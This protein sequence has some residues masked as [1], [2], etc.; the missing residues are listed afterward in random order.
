MHCSWLSNQPLLAD[1]HKGLEILCI[2]V[3]VTVTGMRDCTH[4]GNDY[5]RAR[6]LIRSAISA[7]FIYMISFYI[8]EAVATAYNTYGTSCAGEPMRKVLWFLIFLG[9]CRFTKALCT[10][11]Q[12]K[13]IYVAGAVCIFHFFLRGRIMAYDQSRSF[14][15]YI[16]ID[17]KVLNYSLFY[18]AI[19]PL[20]KK[21]GIPTSDA[22]RPYCSSRRIWI[23]L[24]LMCT[25][26]IVPMCFP[27]WFTESYQVLSEIPAAPIVG[28]GMDVKLLTVH[29][30]QLGFSL[31]F[32]LISMEAAPRHIWFV[33][34]FATQNDKI[35]KYYL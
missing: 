8:S 13:D 35:K 1:L 34:S 5:K 18:F 17:M 6:A 27:Q 7:F 2:P 30:M 12:L 24:L 10:I 23:L 14:A 16:L 25:L 29:L 3:M 26:A 32:I 15:G 19:P 28:P 11:L 9:T 33:N 22:A 31:F 4:K 21:L 20:L